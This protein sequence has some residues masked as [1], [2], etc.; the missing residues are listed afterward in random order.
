MSNKVRGEDEPVKY[1]GH[2]A[3]AWTETYGR[4]NVNVRAREGS[5]LLD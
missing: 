5:S 1:P 3:H 2:L 4:T